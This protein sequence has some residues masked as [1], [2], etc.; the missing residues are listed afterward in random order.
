MAIVAVVALG[1][2][3]V[4]FAR[5]Q[6]GGGNS[7]DT[8]PRAQLAAGEPYD[9]WHAAFDV[10]VCGKQQAPVQDGAQDT[11]GIHTHGDDLI[12]IHPFAT[13]SSGKNAT[14]QRFFDQVGITVTDDGFT[15]QDG[16]VYKEGETTCGGKPGEVVVAYWKQAVGSATAK[17]TKIYTSDFG[18]IRFTENYAAYTLAFEPKG[19]KD[20]PPPSSSE[21][22]KELGACDG[23]NPPA[24]CSSGATSQTI[25]SSETVPATTGDSTAT[26]TG[27]GG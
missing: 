3:I 9:H 27:S 4:V 26:T 6:N 10:N 1:I 15:T 25:P 7:N 16:K 11:L 2:G 20:I 24:S 18:K 17:P 21:Q 13:R 12:H 8:K 14:M 22:I 23:E 5:N 19:T